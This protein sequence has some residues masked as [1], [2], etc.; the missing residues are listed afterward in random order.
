M[1]PVEK[2][3]LLYLKAVVL[4][5]EQANSSSFHTMIQQ[6]DMLWFEYF[7]VKY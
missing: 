5:G 3:L 4:Q 2:S 7:D 1:G 6:V